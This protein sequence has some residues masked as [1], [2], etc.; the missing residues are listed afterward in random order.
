[1][2]VLTIR[3]QSE[4]QRQKA[5]T[6]FKKNNID[7]LEEDEIDLPLNGKPFTEDELEVH[8]EKS[9]EGEYISFEGFK[10]ELKSWN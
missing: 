3:I 10:K 8:L 2:T 1:M 7:F 4:L 6:F 9:A 5:I